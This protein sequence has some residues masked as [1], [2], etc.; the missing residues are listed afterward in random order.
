[1]KRLVFLLVVL[2]FFPACSDDYFKL[3]RPAQ[4]P[5]STL[6]EFE[7]A[8]IGAYG[9][10]FSDR[11]W[12]QAWPNYA[13]I[14]TS[15]GDDVEY[16]NDDQWGYLRQ[17][18]KIPDLSDRNWWLLY[19][20]IGAVNVALDFVKEKDGNPFP[21]ASQ[22][23]MTN[24]VNRIVGELH[25]LRG[26]CYYLLQ[27]TFG[28]PYVPNGA[29]DKINLPLHT[30]F[31]RSAKEATAPKMGSTREVWDL[32]LEDFKRAKEL[33]PARFDPNLH[34]PSYKVRANKFAA[35]GM[36]M[37]TYFQRGEYALAQQECDFLID[38]NGGEYDLSEDPIQ[39]FN[40]SGYAERGREVIWYL[41]YSDQTLYPPS[42]LSVLN[43]TWN[44]KKCRWNET[45][46]GN[47][48]IQ[49]LGWM[50]NPQQNTALKVA[51]LR[52]KRFQQLMIVRYP[53]SS[54]TPIQESDDR[55]EVAEKTSIW[56]AKYYRGPGGDY[57]NVPLLR[58]AE[59]YLTRSI[60]K[61]MNGNKAEA[62]DDLNI[63]RKR[64]WDVQLGGPYLPISAADITAEMI[65]DERVVELFNEADRI[66]YLR[67]LKLNIPE[68]ERGNGTDPY[69]SKKFIWSIPESETLY[70]DGFR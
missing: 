59:V 52:D 66:N 28:D 36:L 8:P 18:E 2:S 65:H 13:V 11:E 5:W 61:F 68:G 16:V 23:E 19:R 10:L 40:K 29:N 30:S 48:T 20:G 54:A 67:G 62:A 27:T 32:I 46:M 35:A 1:M 25:F 45:R 43:H 49:R 6:E 60:I 21:E 33:L 4:N 51:A 22:S 53:K 3:D 70:N 12:V 34:H 63:V 7:R 44:G 69:T 31:A 42:H 17:T 38:Q 55:P 50:D 47:K 57:T 9:I 26:F 56:P 64:A 24:A 58:L 37:R 15:L 41:P 14:M 39:A